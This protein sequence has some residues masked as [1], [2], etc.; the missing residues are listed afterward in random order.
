ML[1][2]PRACYLRDSFH[3]QREAGLSGRFYDT[4][5]WNICT[6]SRRLYPVGC[7]SSQILLTVSPYPISKDKLPQ[8]LIDLQRLRSVRGSSARETLDS[9]WQVYCSA[10][11]RWS[12]RSFQ[13]HSASCIGGLAPWILASQLPWRLS[14]GRARFAVTHWGRRSAWSVKIRYIGISYDNGL[15]ILTSCT[16]KFVSSVNLLVL[17]WIWIRVSASRQT[18]TI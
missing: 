5:R 9:C 7:R 4:S 3:G 11:P 15:I 17:T 6:C 14:S 2:P 18:F 8:C 1:R 12:G 16:R 13:D 10:E